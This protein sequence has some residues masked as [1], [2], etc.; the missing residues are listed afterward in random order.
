MRVAGGLAVIGT[1]LLA[2]CSSGGGTG[3]SAIGE[4]G[5]EISGTVTFWHSY[6]TD[7]NELDTLD[8]DLIP[9]FEEAHP[10]VTVESVPVP[11]DDL[12]QKLV[13]ATAGG[14]LP[15]LVRSD[16]I[17][18]PELADLGVLVPLDDEM[19]DF[20]SYAEQMYPGPL[21]TNRW[22]DHYYGLPLS[23]NTRVLMYNQDALRA[24]G[25]DA[26]PATFEEMRDAA[27]R[28]ATTDTYLF[29]D[30]DTQGWNVLPWIWS[31][32]GDITD[33]DATTSTGYINSAESVEGVQL[34][35][36]L[37]DQGVIPDLI[38][39]TQGGTPTSDGLPSGQYA[40]ILDGP[41]MYPIFGNQ[42]P[43]FDVETAPVPA[44]DAGS[45]SVVGG[46]SV[47]MTQSSKNKAAAAEF[48]RFL[49]SE[50]AQ[51]A[52]AD[53]GQMS[54]LEDFAGQQIETQAYYQQF[55]EQLATAK[56]RTPT[57]AWP[58]IEEV[59]QAQVQ[60]ALRGDASVQEAL[61]E[62]ATQID[63]LLAQYG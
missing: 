38:L 58:R 27:E 5:E 61:D 43:D 35:V 16:V 42:Y 45:I 34:L 52:M 19:P 11:Y 29:A 3:D 33:E 36:D 24:A 8:N 39:G 13:T 4:A 20:D 57:P 12:H 55:V 28:F 15:D 10:G 44:G 7:S 32:G 14:T 62:A 63:T 18:V 50:E 30:N 21:A 6:T 22:Q 1:M 49:L 53:V 48:M 23:T 54:V 56:P 47:V 51:S 46:E 31:A 60:L 37:Y 40:T 25:L 26:P 17:W 2:G 9:R 41:W 59:L